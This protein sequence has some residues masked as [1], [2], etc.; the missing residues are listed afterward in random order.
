[1]RFWV[2]RGTT[3]TIKEQLISQLL[4]S[5]FSGR[6]E[7]GDRLPSVR[8]LA[9][10]LGLHANT[11]S[12]VYQELTVRGWV[13]Q[14]PGSGVYVRSRPP[15]HSLDAIVERF[16]A[17]A[18]AAGHPPTAVLDAL[19]RAVHLSPAPP[20]AVIDPDPA[21]A[22]VIAAELSAQWGEP[23]HFASSAEPPPGYQLWASA[24]RLPELGQSVL[25]VRLVSLEEML[26]SARRPPEN[27]LLAVVSISPTILDWSARILSALGVSP[28]LVLLRNPRHAN[29]ID[30]LSLCGSIG[31]DAVA[32]GLLPAAT[33][34]HVFRV[35]AVQ[36]PS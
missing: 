27:T 28:D 18:E 9:R 7:P 24:G 4:L 20:R 11:I 16:L 3:T 32:A 10:R 26:A 15:S 22:E 21:L 14:R 30:G 25:P 34:H 6:F 12:T 17:E 36:K 2:A 8:Q 33:P 23:V 5:I 31:A 29:G 19:T 13:E 35:V 1:M